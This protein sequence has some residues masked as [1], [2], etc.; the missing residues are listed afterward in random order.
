MDSEVMEKYLMIILGYFFLI[1]P[2]K[3]MSCVV[4]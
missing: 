3:R 1:S 2:R 4:I